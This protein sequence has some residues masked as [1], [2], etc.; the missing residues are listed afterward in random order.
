MDGRVKPTIDVNGAIAND[1]PALESEADVMARKA[2]ETGMH[3]LQRERP[4]TEADR[5][6]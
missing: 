6:S 2:Q 4:L 1:D 5:L 3:T